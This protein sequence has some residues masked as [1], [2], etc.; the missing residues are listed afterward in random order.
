MPG[1]S[2][3]GVVWLCLPM[4][5]NPGLSQ[6]SRIQVPTSVVSHPSTMTDPATRPNFDGIGPSRLGDLSNS[7]TEEEAELLVK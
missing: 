3:T 1:K 2:R 7:G 6:W 4:H 5:S